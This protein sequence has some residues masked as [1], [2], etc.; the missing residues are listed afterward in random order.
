MESGG[1]VNKENI[2]YEGN[3]ESEDNFKTFCSLSFKLKAASS[4][5]V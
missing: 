1:K 4:K 2:C 3:A 5:N